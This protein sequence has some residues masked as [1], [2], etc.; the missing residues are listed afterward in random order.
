MKKSINK[1][2]LKTVFLKTLPV[3]AGYLVL[4]MGFGILLTGKGYGALW[5]FAMSATVFAGSM[6]YVAVDLL[7]SGASLISTAIMTL[8]VNARH[9]FYGISMIDRYKGAGR[10]KTV[11]HVCPYR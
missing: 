7:A 1:T 9:L 4:G 3:M 8:M 2:L 11:S 5:A 6:Q 10:K